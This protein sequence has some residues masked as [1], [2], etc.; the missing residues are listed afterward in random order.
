MNGQKA[1]I[2]SL[3]HSKFV[4]E[5]EG[6]GPCVILFWTAWSGPCIRQENDLSEMAGDFPGVGFRK[7]NCEENPDLS[8]DCDIIVVPTTVFYKEG[9]PT[10]RLVGLQEVNVIR[11]TINKL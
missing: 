8:A 11:E 6:G 4:S 9:R 7:V 5:V 10:K 3:N 1:A 2:S